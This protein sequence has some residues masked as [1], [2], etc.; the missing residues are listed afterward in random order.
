MGLKYAIL[1]IGVNLFPPEGGFPADLPEAGAVYET[2]PDPAETR[3]RLAGRIL[4]HFFRW[5]PAIQDRPFFDVYRNRSMVLGQPISILQ[6]GTSRPASP[7]CRAG[8]AVLPPPWTWSPTSPCGSGRPTGGSP[9]SPPGRSAS[10]RSDSYEIH[11]FF[12]NPALTVFFV[13]V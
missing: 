9:S 4:D 13:G 5:Y 2:S 1:G 7:F 10:A 8:P 6:G 12:T 11:T 3:R